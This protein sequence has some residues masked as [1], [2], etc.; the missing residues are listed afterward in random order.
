MQKEITL[1]GGETSLMKAIGTSG[2]PVS[3]RQL[4]DHMGEI[5]DA[6][7]LDTLAGLLALDY[8]LS[9]KVNIRTREDIERSLFRVNP[10]LSKE[11][12][13]ALNPAHRRLQQDRSRRQRRG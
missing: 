1:D 11:L 7:L 9:N 4:L 10:A 13:E 5:G 2:A 8:V 3:G 6:E 12:R